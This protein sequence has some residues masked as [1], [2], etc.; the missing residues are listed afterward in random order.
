MAVVDTNYRFVTVILP[1]LKIYAMDINS[2][3]YAE[4]T[5]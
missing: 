1:F 2:E 4:I 5:Q 3:K